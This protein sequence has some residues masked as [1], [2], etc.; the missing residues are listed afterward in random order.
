MTRVLKR[1]ENGGTINMSNY[2]IILVVEDW[3][4]AMVNHETPIRLSK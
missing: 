3:G 4:K 2:I 1:A